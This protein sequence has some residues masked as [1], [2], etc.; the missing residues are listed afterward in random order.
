MG[1]GLSLMIVG[2]RSGNGKIIIGKNK[3]LI[4]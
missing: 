4:Y 3:A 1:N 2:L